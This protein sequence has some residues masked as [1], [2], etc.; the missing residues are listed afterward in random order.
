MQ[1][2]VYL[3]L[4]PGANGGIAYITNEGTAEAIKMP[5]SPEEILKLL[6]SF[7]NTPTHACLE[8][9]GGYVGGDHARGSHMFKFGRSYGRLE[10]ALTA[11]SILFQEVTPQEWLAAFDMRREKGETDTKW[12]NRLKAKAQLLYSELNVTLATA[13]ALLIAT[14]CQRKQEGRI[15]EPFQMLPPEVGPRLWD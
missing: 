11:C 2:V 15:H 6:G 9:V 10:T 3:G 14:Y 1:R 5:A 8:K 7:G 13:D 4:D 12:K